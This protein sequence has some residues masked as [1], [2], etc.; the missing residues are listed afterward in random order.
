MGVTV[1]RCR[2][3]TGER[4][5]GS[6]KYGIS[7]TLKVLLDLITVRFMLGYA[8]QPLRVFGAVGLA[9]GGG[10]RAVGIYLTVLKLA[11]GSPSQPPPVI[12]RRA[13]GN[14]GVQ[15]VSMGLLPRW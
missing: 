1:P 9:D 3:T 10:W 11:L 2:S 8:N 14:P 5:F 4:R 12:A 7:R 15:M 6:S 13:V